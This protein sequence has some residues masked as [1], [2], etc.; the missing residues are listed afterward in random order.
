MILL[1]LALGRLRFVV[2]LLVSGLRGLLLFRLPAL[3]LHLLVVLAL[4]LLVLLLVGTADGLLL[5]LVA[6][7]LFQE[8]LEIDL[9]V[10]VGRVEGERLRVGVHGFLGLA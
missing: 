1:F 7:L 3:L 8:K 4:L 6:L 10:P 2:L 9:R 5:F